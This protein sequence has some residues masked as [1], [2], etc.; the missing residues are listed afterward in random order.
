[1]YILS[2]SKTAAYLD[3]DDAA[4]VLPSVTDDNDFADQ[5]TFRLDTV[6]YKESEKTS[7]QWE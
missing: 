7:I 2:N 6:L 1:M 3:G 5:I 4:E